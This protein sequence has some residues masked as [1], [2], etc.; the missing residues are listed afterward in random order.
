MRRAFT[1][2]VAIASGLAAAA[3]APAT[4]SAPAD[5][6]LEAIEQTLVGGRL[7]VA[8]VNTANGVL[9]QSRG[10][11]RFAMCSTF[12]WILA[13][14]I[15]A[16]VQ[17]GALRLGAQIHYTQADL[18]EY[19]PVTRANVARGWMTI[20]ALCAA[21]VEQSDNTAANLLLAQIGGPAGL[22]TFVRAHGDRVTRFDRTEPELNI[23][24]AGDVRD[25]STPDAMVG[26]MQR[27]LLSD[28]ALTQG[29]RAK[30]IDWLTQSQTG[31]DRLRAGLPA[32]WRVGDKTGTSGHGAA[33]DLAIVWPPNRAPILIACFVDAPAADDRI[34]NAAHAAVARLVA[35]SWS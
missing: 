1:R 30:L 32:A 13:A 4:F 2:R 11:E 5:P 28:A 14:D 18:L 31:A 33:N 3:Y 35:T 10:E 24:V 29:S 7:G 26:D 16:R 27:L 12:K 6:R 17:S 25:T 34:R 20:E 9:L 15:L 19:A 21:A 23:V 22:T 8:A